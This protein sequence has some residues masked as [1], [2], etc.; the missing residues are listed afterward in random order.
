MR[1]ILSIDPGYDRCGIA[2]IEK[3]SDGS[4]ILLHSV[5]LTTEKSLAFSE[6]LLSLKNELTLLVEKY[7]PNESAIEKLFFTKNTKTALLVAESC[8]VIRV[9]LEELTLKPQEY[10]PAQIKIAVTGYGNA[11]KGA[12]SFMVRKLIS[13]PEEKKL[14]DELDAIAVGITHAFTFNNKNLQ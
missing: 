10:T 13:V 14:D 2:F 5:C 4:L 8:G 12:V 6:R 7:K 11:D 1:R 9:T 3:E